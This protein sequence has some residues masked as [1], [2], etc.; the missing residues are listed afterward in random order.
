MQIARAGE[1]ERLRR[2]L[3]SHPVVGILGPRQVGKTTLARRL[4]KGHPG[5]S[6]AFD[7]EDPADAARLA[8]A[9]LTLEPL[10]GRPYRLP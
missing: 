9:R 5:A 6:T 2:L 3:R 1:L 10:R 4:M 8:D 7:L